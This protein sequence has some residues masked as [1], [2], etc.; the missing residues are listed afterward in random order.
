[1]GSVLESVVKFTSVIVHR[2]KLRNA[3]YNPRKISDKAKKKL[4][5]NI[6]RVWLIDPPIW[7]IRT[8][9]IVGG[10]Q[11]VAILDAIAGTDDYELPVSQVDMDE[12][13]EKEQNVFLN[14]T[15]AQGD[16]DLGKLAS[17]FKDDKINNDNSGF[18]LA[19]VYQMFGDSPV[20]DQ[21]E[22]LDELAEQIR[23]SKALYDEIKEKSRNRD[24]QDYYSVVVFANESERDEA[25]SLL[26]AD[27]DN[28]FVCGK[29]LL[30]WLREHRGRQQSR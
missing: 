19:D 12:L 2:S 26:G 8:G 7:N 27:T 9:N 11:R 5:R 25:H 14:N 29:D 4:K 1:M 24:T 3:S 10:H 21:P 16:F 18:D 17:M 30:E 20:I 22:S 23:K 13:T 28:R 6:E 15:E